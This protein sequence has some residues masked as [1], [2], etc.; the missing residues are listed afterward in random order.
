MQEVG[1]RTFLR[2]S[3]KK[4]GF[5]EMFGRGLKNEREAWG[6]C[7]IV[8]VAFRTLRWVQSSVESVILAFGWSWE[9][10]SRDLTRRCILEHFCE[11]R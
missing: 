9:R 2:S 1:S 3:N 6:G 11:I 4:K 7:V 10:F 5:H 8:V